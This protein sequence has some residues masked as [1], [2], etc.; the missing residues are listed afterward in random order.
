M[1]STFIMSCIVILMTC[2]SGCAIFPDNSLD[3]GV[4]EIGVDELETV[5]VGK[6]TIA[7]IVL[8]Y[9]E[10]STKNLEDGLL[11]YRWYGGDVGYYFLFGGGSLKSWKG[12]N[13]RFDDNGVLTRKIIVDPHERFSEDTLNIPGGKS[14]I[15]VFTTA[16]P[17]G[18][19]VSQ[20][21]PVLV[22]DVWLTRLGVNQFSFIVTDPGIHTFEIPHELVST[23]TGQS[24]NNNV[25]TKKVDEGEIIFLKLYASRREF[26]GAP[27]FPIVYSFVIAEEALI[28]LDTFSILDG[29]ALDRTRFERVHHTSN[30]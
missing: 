2:F 18:V 22:N 20:T 7:D 3:Y 19:D 5:Q 27:P 9:G 16:N 26:L 10:P 24:S 1:D 23:E 21:I 13:L 29:Y 15:L 14:A 6:S 4:G 8:K 11:V 25:I 28:E 17:E 30:R 12:V